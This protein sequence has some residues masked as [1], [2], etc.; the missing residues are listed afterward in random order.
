MHLINE[1]HQTS[2][3]ILRNPTHRV[4]K[5]QFQKIRTEQDAR[6]QTR[7][8]PLVPLSPHLQG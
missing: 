5:A 6:F 8:S 3:E 7:R 2:K 1:P 4:N